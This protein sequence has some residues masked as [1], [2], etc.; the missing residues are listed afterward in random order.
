MQS[1]EEPLIQDKGK[2]YP[3]SPNLYPSRECQPAFRYA[4]RLR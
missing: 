2:F 3:I 1:A 4:S